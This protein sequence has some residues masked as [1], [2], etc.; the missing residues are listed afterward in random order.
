MWER[1]T[2]GR[3][4]NRAG[5]GMGMAAGKEV[6]WSCTGRQF[7]LLLRL[8]CGLGANRGLRSASGEKGLGAVGA[9][10]GER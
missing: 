8:S 1:G 5:G 3:R 6:P 2:G 7:R 4:E 10:L 9:A